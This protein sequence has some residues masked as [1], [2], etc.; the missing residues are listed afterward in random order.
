MKCRSSILLARLVS[1][2][3]TQYLNEKLKQPASCFLSL[4][5]LK[6]D[7]WETQSKFLECVKEWRYSSSN[8]ILNITSVIQQI[9]SK[10][11]FPLVD[12]F[13][14]L[15]SVTKRNY[16]HLRLN[17][18]FSYLLRCTFTAISFTK[19]P[20][21]SFSILDALCLALAIRSKY[22]TCKW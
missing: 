5:F 18:P 10:I 1:W 13:L 3:F 19:T 8:Q 15:N 4:A 7:I 21:S 6:P 2:V 16:I 11:I 9:N 14:E 22:K 12:E 17:E 20:M